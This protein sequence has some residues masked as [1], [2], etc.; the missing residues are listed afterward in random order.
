[1]EELGRQ[2]LIGAAEGATVVPPAGKVTGAGKKIFVKQAVNEGAEN[3]F[4]N[5]TK[6]VVYSGVENAAENTFKTAAR[7]GVKE[8]MVG[9]AVTGAVD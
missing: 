9:G 2:G 4:K 7:Q 8:G 6:L 3:V 5:T 1:V